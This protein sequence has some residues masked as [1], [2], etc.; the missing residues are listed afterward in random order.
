VSRPGG[1]VRAGEFLKD[2]WDVPID[3]RRRVELELLLSKA[4]TLLGGNRP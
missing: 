3:W 2:R 1:R 4:E